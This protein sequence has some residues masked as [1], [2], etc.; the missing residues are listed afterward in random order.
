MNLFKL[1][2]ISFNQSQNETSKEFEN[3]VS[4]FKLVRAFVRGIDSDSVVFVRFATK[5]N[6]IEFDF[7]VHSLF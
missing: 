6:P 7:L 5:E 4:D 1:N 2:L 3:K